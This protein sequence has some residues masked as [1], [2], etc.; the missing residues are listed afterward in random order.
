MRSPPCGVLATRA[1]IRASCAPCAAAGRWIRRSGAP[2][3]PSFAA[4]LA[5]PCSF[6]FQLF[7]H[8]LRREGTKSSFSTEP[9]T[10]RSRIHCVQTSLGE[11]V[12][13]AHG[14]PLTKSRF[15]VALE[16]GRAL[17]A[18]EFELRA[19][20]GKRGAFLFELIGYL[21]RDVWV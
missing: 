13:R 20:E 2:G 11:K 18:D 5:C 14:R 8:L 12:L 7:L 19:F 21:L 17:R 15:S 1:Q 16:R 9:S 6:A 4:S 3:R 10:S